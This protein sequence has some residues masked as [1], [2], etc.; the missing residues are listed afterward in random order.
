[1]G[2]FCGIV[3]ITDG[4]AAF[5]KVDGTLLSTASDDKEHATRALR[6]HLA[7]WVLDKF[8]VQRSTLSKTLQLG[9]DDKAHSMSIKCI[10]RQTGR[11]RDR[12]E[13]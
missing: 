8:D 12:N 4:T 13:Q 7:C 5:D 11:E 1:V 2:G 10:P 6:L 9:I 3:W